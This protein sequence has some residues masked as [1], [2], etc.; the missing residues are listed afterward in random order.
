[1]LLVQVTGYRNWSARQIDFDNVTAAK[2]LWRPTL[3]TINI[4][5][6][7]RDVSLNYR[8]TMSFNRTM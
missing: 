4:K 6:L 3:L 7:T 1:M 5:D 2:C 8:I